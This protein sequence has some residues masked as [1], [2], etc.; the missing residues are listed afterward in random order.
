MG[1]PGYGV[2]CPGGGGGVALR[3]GHRRVVS[4]EPD[5]IGSVSVGVVMVY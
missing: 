2:G 5:L 4:C 3:V 1:E